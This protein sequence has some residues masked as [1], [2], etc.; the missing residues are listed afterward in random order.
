MHL[1]SRYMKYKKFYELNRRSGCSIFEKN[2]VTHYF[3]KKFDI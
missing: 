2:A 1:D 3:V